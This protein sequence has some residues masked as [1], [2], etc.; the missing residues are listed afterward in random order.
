MR[1][2]ALIPGGMPQSQARLAGFIVLSIGLHLVTAL[3]AG[4]LDLSGQRFGDA[5]PARTT[6]HATLQL[7]DG[8]QPPAAQPADQAA[9]GRD[10][11]PARAPVEAVS[12]A[13][14]STS[15]AGLGLPAADK[16][17]TASEVDLRAEPLTDI[18]LHYPENL[19]ARVAGKVRV[20]LFIDEGGVVRRLQIAS[21]EP[22]GMF[23]EAARLTW[24]GVRFSPARKNGAAVKSQKLLELT[25]A[26][27]GP[28]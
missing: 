10:A 2:L 14:A 23:D 11:A 9:T 28:F 21:S 27:T 4:R 18:R 16:W 5:A 3:G 17:Y 24:E 1:I 13:G 6:L 22:Q 12:P 7:G 26:P 8:A 25:Y 15:A 20:R 19:P